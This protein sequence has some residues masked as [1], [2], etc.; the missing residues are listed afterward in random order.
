MSWWY[1]SACR[2]ITSKDWKLDNLHLSVVCSKHD[3]QYIKTIRLLTKSK[4]LL[5]AFVWKIL[6]Y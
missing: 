4:Y 3:V 2:L 1:C 5:K 6:Y